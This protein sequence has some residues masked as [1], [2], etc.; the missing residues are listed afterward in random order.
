MRIRELTNQEPEQKT[1][2]DRKHREQR[3]QPDKA[4]VAAGTRKLFLLLAREFGKMG[5][6]RRRDY[7]DGAVTRVALNR[8]RAKVDELRL[9]VVAG[10]IGKRA[11]EHRVGVGVAKRALVVYK[12]MQFAF[13]GEI[14]QQRHDKLPFK[15]RGADAR[16]HMS[17]YTNFG[18]RGKRAQTNESLLWNAAERKRGCQGAIE[19]AVSTVAHND[20]TAE[21]A[22]RCTPHP[23]GVTRT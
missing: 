12:T 6:S 10:T 23:I 21:N 3:R 22:E 11:A 9:Q 17:H 20:Y 7:H 18:Q 8:E 15:N 16:G 14:E 13:L 4:R 19:A 5:V 2:E 1:H